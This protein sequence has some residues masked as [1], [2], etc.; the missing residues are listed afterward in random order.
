MDDPSLSDKHRIKLLVG[1][2]LSESQARRPLPKLGLKHRKVASIPGKFD[3][4]LQFALYEQQILIER[5]WKL[6][7]KKCQTN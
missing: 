5:L 3:T 1:V 4:Q 6:T 7:K 2:C